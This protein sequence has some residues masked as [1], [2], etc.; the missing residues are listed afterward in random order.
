MTPRRDAEPPIHSPVV[1]V[2]KAVAIA[3]LTAVFTGLVE[4]GIDEL[5]EK[6]GKARPRSDGESSPGGKDKA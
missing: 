2:A 6:Y 4:W 5:R 1:E 3:A